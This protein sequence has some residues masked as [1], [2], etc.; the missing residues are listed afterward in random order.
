MNPVIQR[1]LEKI[2]YPLE[3]TESTTHL[4]IPKKEDIFVS[5]ATP[6]EVGRCYLVKLAPYILNEPADFTLSSNWNKGVVPKSRFMNISVNKIAGKMLNVDASGVND[7]GVTANTE[8]HV[9][10]WLPLGGIQVI[11]KI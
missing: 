6:L 5:D 7:D 3:Y 11:T 10:F 9:D 8:V 2:R 4:V 1:E